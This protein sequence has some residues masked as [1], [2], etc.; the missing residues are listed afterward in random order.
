MITCNIERKDG[1][2][3]AVKVT[4]HSEYDDIG[5]DIVCAAVSAL[6]IATVNGLCTFVKVEVDYLIKDDGF[7]EFK[8]PEIKDDKKILQSNAILETL[9]LGLKSI[10]IEYNEYI[11]IKVRNGGAH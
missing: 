7:L 6:T 2:I 10:E 3:V 5:K 8:I 9:Y 1:N 4:G 11:R